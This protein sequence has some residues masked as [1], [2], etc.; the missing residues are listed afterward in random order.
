MASHDGEVMPHG[1]ITA[2]NMTLQMVCVM[3]EGEA[4]AS[5][6]P[7]LPCDEIGS[8]GCTSLE[9]NQEE[10]CNSSIVIRVTCGSESCGEYGSHCQH[11]NRCPSTC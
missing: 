5:V 7:I 4:M 8:E 9:M 2:S 10:G 11:A 3:Q 6:W 1:T